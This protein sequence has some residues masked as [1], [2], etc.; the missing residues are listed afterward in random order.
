MII[1]SYLLCFCPSREFFM[2][3][4]V[5]FDAFM[6]PRICA[7]EDIGSSIN[8]LSA[9]EVSSLFYFNELCCGQKSQHISSSQKIIAAHHKWSNATCIDSKTVPISGSQKTAEQSQCSIS[10]SFCSNMSTMQK[11]KNLDSANMLMMTT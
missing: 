3:T 11:S 8:D 1:N 9:Y 2:E 4:P 6:C 7:K 5:N 10:K